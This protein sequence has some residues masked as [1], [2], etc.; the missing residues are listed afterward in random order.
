MKERIE[1]KIQFF[2]GYSRGAI[3]VGAVTP[4]RRQKQEF[5]SGVRNCSECVEVGRQ[6]LVSHHVVT[7]TIIQE[8][9]GRQFRRRQNIREEPTN[10]DAGSPGLFLSLPQG[11][12]R[13]IQRR[14]IK[15]LARQVDGVIAT[16]TAQIQRP[17][18]TNLV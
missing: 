14:N 18:G 5:R 11:R 9:K 4:L 12:R 3:L 10:G 6:V 16:P 8:I 15:P 17:A 2:L 13:H 1:V 7:A